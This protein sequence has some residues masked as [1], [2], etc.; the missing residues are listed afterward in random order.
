[1]FILRRTKTQK[2]M[3]KKILELPNFDVQTLV[4]ELAPIHQLYYNR[5]YESCQSKFR[6]IVDSG[7]LMNRTFEVFELLTR[8]RQV[9]CH[10]FL[11]LRF[12]DS[13]PRKNNR[14]SKWD[15]RKL[16]HAYENDVFKASQEVKAG[17]ELGLRRNGKESIFNMSDDRSVFGCMPSPVFYT[18][19]NKN[20]LECTPSHRLG[21]IPFHVN[22]KDNS[23]NKSSPTHDQGKLLL[24]TAVQTNRKRRR[25]H[26]EDGVDAETKK[27]SITVTPIRVL[28]SP[29]TMALPSE[30]H[31]NE[32][33]RVLDAPDAT[34]VV[35]GRETERPLFVDESMVVSGD[36]KAGII[37]IDDDPAV[38][39]SIITLNEED[40][41]ASTTKSRLPVDCCSMSNEI[42]AANAC[43]ARLQPPFDFYPVHSSIAMLDSTTRFNAPIPSWA[44]MATATDSEI[45]D[46]SPDIHYS[47]QDSAHFLSRPPASDAKSA[48]LSCMVFIYFILFY[49]VII[50]N[51]NYS[52]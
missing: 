15:I 32:A 2:V 39:S 29:S 36:S 20:E 38:D 33:G 8:L 27:K 49:Y 43:E 47:Y 40:E 46:L 28:N 22:S 26:K 35:R 5:V 42:E 50:I 18:V 21:R 25:E 12:T 45:E 44:L 48:N 11:A 37:D 7:T 4:I 19:Q 34:N 41:D 14:N 24:E 10:P 31:S 6:S 13:E 51:H 23:E 3:G 30:S 52:F 1:M 17:N 16:E 9:A